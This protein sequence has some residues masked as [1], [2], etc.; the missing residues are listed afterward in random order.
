MNKSLH[1]TAFAFT[2]LGVT[3]ASGSYST[4]VMAAD[5]IDMTDEVRASATSFAV[6]SVDTDPIFG[7]PGDD[8]YI[9]GSREEGSSSVNYDGLDGNDTI[10]GDYK[11][12]TGDELSANSFFNDTLAGSAGD[13][14]IYGESGSFWLSWYLPR[15]SQSIVAGNDLIS[16]G[17][18]QDFLYGGGDDLFNGGKSDDR[19]FVLEILPGNDVINGENGADYIAGDY[20][21]ITVLPRETSLIA[22]RTSEAR[23]VGGNDELDGG[24][25]DDIIYG[26]GVSLKA[27]SDSSWAYLEFD[28]YPQAPL[29]F[30]YA[31][32]EAGDDAIKGG[33]G[34]DFISGDGGE[35]LAEADYLL[36]GE[37]GGGTASHLITAGHDELRG[38][39]GKDTIYGDGE[40]ATAR[41]LNN[42]L[43]QLFSVS[44]EDVSFV[45]AGND[46]IN[47]GR[48]SD[49]LIGDFETARAEVLADDD[50]IVMITGGSDVIRG[51]KGADTIYGD[52]I[53]V[54]IAL[55]NAASSAAIAAGNDTIEGG[56][57]DDEIWGDAVEV[58]VISG[59]YS[60]GQDTFV[61]RPG[62]GKDTIHDFE[63]DQD[64]IDVSAFAITAFEELQIKK[65]GGSTLIIL[66]SHRP[67]DKIK[68]QNV[69]GLT[70]KNFIF[71]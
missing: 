27:Y 49:T 64:F 28:E 34:D 60:T 39:K 22:G 57:G 10:Y 38:G 53:N 31:I 15:V 66:S 18:G 1:S 23:F 14:V 42:P 48:G 9:N 33:R 29:T 21:R 40:N 62:S 11:R 45:L 37:E 13:D 52:F 59:D 36:R 51:G 46:T 20:N 54:A 4:A 68:I 12:F 70:S 58:E 56:P 3:L 19:D 2:I 65:R 6:G 41:N 61:F 8:V 26:E 50:S 44:H 24:N 25:S 67:R 69:T 47:G 43:V 16:G 71:K 63:L 17:D 55:G 35:L 7:T 32:I 30:N 5:G